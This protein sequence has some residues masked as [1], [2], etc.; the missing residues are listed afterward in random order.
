MPFDVVRRCVQSLLEPLEA[1]RLHE[2]KSE[3]EA[4]AVLWAMQLSR[5]L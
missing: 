3:G 1:V 4:Q 5:Q 2:S